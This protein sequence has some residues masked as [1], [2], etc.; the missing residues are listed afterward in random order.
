MLAVGAIGVKST[1]RQKTE[2]LMEYVLTT[3]LLLDYEEM[4]MAR[5]LMSLHMI[6]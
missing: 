1:D 4:S 2:R 3:L 6:D 5:E